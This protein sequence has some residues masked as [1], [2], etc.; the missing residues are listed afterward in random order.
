M[1]AKSKAVNKW[2]THNSRMNFNNH[3]YDLASSPK[4]VHFDPTALGIYVQRVTLGQLQLP[5][6]P[7]HTK[8]VE[9][10]IAVCDY[11]TH[12]VFTR[13][14]LLL[15]HLL[16][17][18]WVKNT[19]VQSTQKCHTRT[20]GTSV[21]QTYIH[22]NFQESRGNCVVCMSNFRTITFLRGHCTDIFWVQYHKWQYNTVGWFEAK[23]WFKFKVYFSYLHALYSYRQKPS[24]EK[25]VAYLFMIKMMCHIGIAKWLTGVCYSL[26]KKKK[27]HQETLQRNSF[28]NN[29]RYYLERPSHIYDLI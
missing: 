18:L 14:E 29:C 17:I 11:Q 12:P 7:P 25:T 19:K 15:Q 22:C 1:T 26:I 2:G 8:H 23:T 4:C 3:S 10:S 27:Q 13:Q 24:T 20:K 21:C 9:S 6:H 5:T 16:K 28:K